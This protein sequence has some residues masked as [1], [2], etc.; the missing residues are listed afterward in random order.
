[1]KYECMFERT[2]SS[3]D[4]SYSEEEFDW[5]CP[6]SLRKLLA[7]LVGL[8]GWIATDTVAPQ[9]DQLLYLLQNNP[10]F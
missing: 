5:L 1:M 9:K 4:Q 6:E 7:L 3:D 2:V 10:Q 8:L